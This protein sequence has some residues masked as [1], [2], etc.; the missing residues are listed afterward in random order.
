MAARRLIR[1]RYTL[2]A[3]LV[4]IT[5]FM[6]W[7]GYHTNRGWKERAALRVLRQNGASISRESGT[8]Y[9]GLWGQICGAYRSV[10]SR[11]WGEELVTSVHLYTLDPELIDAVVL[12]PHLK[13]FGADFEY[14]PASER[15]SLPTD[16]YCLG[17]PP[18]GAIA[19]ILN[20][21]EL[22]QLSLGQWTVDTGDLDRISHHHSLVG[23]SIGSTAMTEAQLAKILHMP[24]LRHLT[25]CAATFKEM[26]LN[27]I[28]G[29]T[30]LES[31][32]C[33]GSAIPPKL[34]DFVSR[35]PNM[36]RLH[37]STKELNDDFVAALAN[38]R[39]L[40]ELILD[41]NGI[42][43]ESAQALASLSSLQLLSVRSDCLSPVAIQKIKSSNPAL[44][45]IMSKESTIP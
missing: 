23:L 8:N 45:I 36:R 38:H 10:V 3:L 29:S 42:T 22:T 28:V 9:A 44:T 19:R 14:I 40:I 4:F 18:E 32:S 1:F 6:L 15:P 5:L 34:A 11:L 33:T 21:H 39:G 31:L 7:G 37:V 25:I 43:D 13:S 17:T 26:Q 24:H 41:G 20:R 12:L 27:D 35:S 30:T 2:R 16:Q